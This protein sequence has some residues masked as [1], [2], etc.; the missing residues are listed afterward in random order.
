MSSPS[1]PVVRCSSLE[2]LLN[3]PGS[4]TIQ[5]LCPEQEDSIVSSAGNYAHHR[6]AR[7]MIDEFDAIEPEGGL[8]E[9]KLVEKFKPT[10][11]DDWMA[12]YFVDEMTLRTQGMALIVE[13]HLEWDFGDFIL[14]GHIDAYGISGDGMDV[15]GGDL[16]SGADPVDPATSNEQ[17]SGYL[18]LLTL[19]FPELQRASFRIIQPRNTGD[20]GHE[21]TSEIFMTS[22]ED[23]L[24]HAK[25]LEDAIRAA[26]KRSREVETGKWCR[27][28]P[29]FYGCPAVDLEIE[30][31]KAI[32]T[33]EV[34][35]SMTRKPD[36]DKLVE[37][38]H[39]RKTT[40]TALKQCNE[41]LIARVKELGGT[42]RTSLG[43]EVAVTPR[44]GRRTITNTGVFIKR[45][46]EDGVKGTALFDCLSGSAG[47]AE[48]ALA[49]ANGVPISGKKEV[50][51]KTL[52][53]KRYDD[54]IDQSESDTLV[55]GKQPSVKEG[56][57]GHA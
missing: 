35:A 41:M 52:L 22:R 6:A 50:T 24:A 2:Q 42:A 30:Y 23:L 7:R 39:F 8:E 9:P 49:K 54:I 37:I 31:M 53:K 40:A 27:Y 26:L 36:L 45:L 44:K 55:L 5:A 56:T 19:N 14:S 16:K 15:D 46:Q 43:Q 20:A 33:D 13:D 11:F 48:R 3:C 1:K 57:A 10:P 17:V 34:L 4:R 21:P 38:E 51:G 29:A 12:D 32:L 25:Q 28:C 47:D 18:T